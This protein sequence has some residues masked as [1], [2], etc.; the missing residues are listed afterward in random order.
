MPNAFG[1]KTRRHW[2]TVD[3][4][5]C[6][7]WF[8]ERRAH[9]RRP[10]STRQE[11]AARVRCSTIEPRAKPGRRSDCILGPATTA[12]LGTTH[13][14]A[15]AAV[16]VLAEM[17][18]DPTRTQTGRILEMAG[19]ATAGS[20]YSALQHLIVIPHTKPNLPRST[21]LKAY[22]VAG[23]KIAVQ[24]GQ[25]ALVHE[26]ASQN[27]RFRR[28]IGAG[29]GRPAARRLYRADLFAPAKAGG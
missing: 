10:H 27:S 15:G 9:E 1:A 26:P 28:A 5:S 12:G 16:S 19:P 29:P 20:D 8:L 24:L 4:G 11:A 25:A 18:P 2:A 22:R 21:I 7:N 6:A 17:T 3:A 23:V 13:V 14:L